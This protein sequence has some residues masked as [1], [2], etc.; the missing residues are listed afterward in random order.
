MSGHDRPISRMIDVDRAR[1][2]DRIIARLQAMDAKNLRRPIHCV[3]R[4]VEAPIPDAGHGFGHIDQ[5]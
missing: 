1:Q 4:G 5:A 3:S 2:I